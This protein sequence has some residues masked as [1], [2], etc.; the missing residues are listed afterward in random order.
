MPPVWES[1]WRIVT[2]DG[3]VLVGVVGQVRGDRLVQ[4]QHA[5]LDQLQR[6]HG[7][8]H[9]VH[10]AD[11][12]LVSWRVGRSRLTVGQPPRLLEQHL[13]IAGDQHGT[14]ELVGRRRARRRAP[15]VPPAPRFRSGGAGQDRWRRASGVAGSSM[16]APGADRLEADVVDTGAHRTGVVGLGEAQADR[17]AG[18]SD[19]SKLTSVGSR[20]VG[21]AASVR[22]TLASTSPSATESIGAKGR[23]GR[24]G[25]AGS[26]RARRRPA[27]QGC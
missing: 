7:G 25:T 18:Q 11:P 9:L 14:G 5:G 4:R 27:C 15:T 16:P 8:E 2:F 20:L 19:T 10:R 12:E 22:K 23:R 17:L 3:E 13:A 6:R 24:Y 26:A 1:R 21:S